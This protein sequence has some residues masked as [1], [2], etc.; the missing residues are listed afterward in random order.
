MPS[1][2]PSISHAA[3]VHPEQNAQTEISDIRLPNTNISD[4]FAALGAFVFE[5]LCRPAALN[6]RWKGLR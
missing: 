3:V 5:L 2:V 1:R 6:T 4:E